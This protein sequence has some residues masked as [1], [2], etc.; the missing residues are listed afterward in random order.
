MQINLKKM[1]YIEERNFQVELDEE[2]IV[3]EFKIAI[4][5]RSM[6]AKK[7]QL[8]NSAANNNNSSSQNNNRVSSRHVHTAHSLQTGSSKSKQQHL[9][10][11]EINKAVAKYTKSSN[12]VNN[13][14]NSS[15]SN[16]N[17]KFLSNN[18]N[19]IDAYSFDEDQLSS[20]DTLNN[21]LKTSNKNHDSES[22]TKSLRSLNNLMNGTGNKK[23]NLRNKYS[24]MKMS[25]GAKK[26]VKKLRDASM[27]LSKVNYLK[28]PSLKLSIDLLT[29]ILILQQL[30]FQEW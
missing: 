20:M 2:K 16:N 26:S 25:N 10:S 17:F 11:A 1:F 3:N 23:A 29:D 24:E 18:R 22:D 8:S 15:T 30:E 14:H 4:K 5:K 19:P 9:N 28:I 27:Q 21:R 13:N 12:A 7:N 6:H